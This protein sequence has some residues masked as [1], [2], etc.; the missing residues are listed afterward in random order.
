MVHLHDHQTKGQFVELARQFLEAGIVKPSALDLAKRYDELPPKEIEWAKIKRTVSR[1]SIRD[2]TGA[3]IPS[4][5]T[6]KAP[7]LIAVDDMTR[8]TP[9]QQ[10]FWLALFDHAQVVTCASEK[11]QGLRKLWWKM[12]EIEVPPLTL[13]ASSEMVRTYIAQKGILIESP[14]LYISHVVKQSG[15]NPQALHDMLSGAAGG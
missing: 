3:I 15:G 1:L 4:L 5:S 7:V 9:T 12:K 8:L 13:E 6:H 10:A 11:K 2:L 14:E